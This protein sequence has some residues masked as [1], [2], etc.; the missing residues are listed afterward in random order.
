[1]LENCQDLRV[2]R[3]PRLEMKIDKDG[4]GMNVAQL[5][6]GEKCT[7]VLFGDLARRLAIA[8]PNLVDP[9]LGEGVVLIDEVEL[10]MHPS[11]QR[12]VLKKLRTTFPNMQ[13]IIT[14][15]SPII[16]SEVDANYKFYYM[17]AEDGDVTPTSVKRLDGYDANAIMEQFMETKSV[18]SDTEELIKTIYSNISKGKYADATENIEKLAEL[19]SENHPDVIA[20]R[21]EMKRRKG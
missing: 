12:K 17:Q 2:A 14:T 16:L 21:M 4:I 10:H 7:M 20:S 6:D 13:F 18:N 19:T 15:H 9:L 5:S 11:W 8:N 1:M 3:K